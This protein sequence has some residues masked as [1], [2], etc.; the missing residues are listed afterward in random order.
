ME[1]A[2]LPATDFVLFLVPEKVKSGYRLPKIDV[3]TAPY[4]DLRS[5][6]SMLNKVKNANIPIQGKVE[7]LRDGLREY[8][9]GKETP[10]ELKATLVKEECPE[11]ECKDIV[12]V[13]LGCKAQINE[14]I[15][16]LIEAANTAPDDDDELVIA[17]TLKDLENEV[18]S[19]K[20]SLNL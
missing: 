2:I 15:D 8:Y 5:H 16:T 12:D 14:A 1:D 19:I 17:T 13:L 4:N 10:E 11:D 9:G 18:N 20:S 6:I 3:E 7:D